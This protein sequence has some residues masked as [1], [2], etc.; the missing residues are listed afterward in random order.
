MIKVMI[1]GFGPLEISCVVTDPT[2]THSFKGG[3]SRCRQLMGLLPPP[4]NLPSAPLTRWCWHWPAS[5]SLDARY[6]KR[7]PW[8][9]L[10]I[11]PSPH[12]RILRDVR[13][14]TQFASLPGA[15]CQS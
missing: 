13:S 7:E 10:P 8:S 6:A 1:P 5:I 14:T 3:L 15:R 12:H 9:G 11:C 2:G 4:L